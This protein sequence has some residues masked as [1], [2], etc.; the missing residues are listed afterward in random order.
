[1]STRLSLLTAVVLLAVGPV[2]APGQDN[3][4]ARP[5]SVQELSLLLRSGYTGDEVLRETAGRPLLAPI[6][7]AAERALLAAGADA[8]TV[9]ALRDGHRL[10]S[11]A[12]AAD[13]Q[14]RQAAAEQHRLE[15]WEAAQAQ[16]A[17]ASRQAVQAKLAARREDQLQLVGKQMRD[18]LVQYKDG[19]LGPYDNAALANKKVFLLYV[20]ASWCGPCRRLTPALVDFYKKYAPTHPEFEFVLI[21]ADRSAADM[22]KYVQTEG[23]PWPALAWEQLAQQPDLA[24]LGK[25]GIPRLVLIDGSGQKLADNFEDGKFVSPQ[26]VIDVLTGNPS[27][28]AAPTAAR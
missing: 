3:P 10:A 24:A 26:H 5:V 8:R 15:S 20:S 18:K 27:K 4:A 28:P 16:R 22:E 17:E 23:M 11:T 1:M 25:E 2:R 7:A 21:P 14:Q 6:D 12:E 9:A 19:H 13:A